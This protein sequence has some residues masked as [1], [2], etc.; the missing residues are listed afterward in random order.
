M[1]HREI[2]HGQSPQVAGVVQAVHRSGAAGHAQVCQCALLLA[3]PYLTGDSLVGY[4]GWRRCDILSW[5]IAA[6]RRDWA[7][8]VTVA[9]A[10]PARLD[11][12]R[13]ELREDRVW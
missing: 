4:V 10:L 8:G 12:C 9:L 2:P 6:V 13:L 1:A 11:R 3:T 7:A 5:T